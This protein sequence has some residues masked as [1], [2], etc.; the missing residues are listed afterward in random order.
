MGLTGILVGLALLMWLAYRGWSILLAAPA[1]AMLTA[2]IAGEPLLAHWTET[3]MGGTSR[4]VFVAY[5]MSCSA[6]CSAS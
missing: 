1:A 5:P 6:A 3:F 4:F 2:L